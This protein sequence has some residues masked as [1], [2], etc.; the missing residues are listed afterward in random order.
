MAEYPLPNGPRQLFEAVRAPLAE[1]IGGEHRFRLGGG[2]ALAMRWAHRHSTDV[3]L[4]TDR[5]SYKRLW[6]R[7]DAFKP[8]VVES[9][10]PTEVL[11]VRRWNT[12]IVL[13]EGGEVT[14]FTSAPQTDE[15][16]STDT[17]AGTKVPLETN[18]E[19]LAKKLWGRM[20]DSEQLLLRDL[21]DFA[22]AHHHDPNAADAA[23]QHIDVS[24]LQQLKRELE[25][26]P[27]GW[28]HR[29][30]QRPLIRPTYPQEAADPTPFVRAQVWREILSRTPERPH[31]PPPAWER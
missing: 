3:D 22:V 14:L 21:Y 9:A 20:L 1:H 30:G 24:D 26:L 8:A 2:T 27:Q 5:G 10:G 25:T 28:R 12:K 23:L 15:P 19:I 11:A 29:S 31:R 18:A 16:R 7:R 17:I 13:L 4:F 6:Q